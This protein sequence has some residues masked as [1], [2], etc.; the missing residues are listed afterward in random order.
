MIQL[1]GVSK[2]YG[3]ELGQ[4]T[5]LHSTSLDINAGELVAIVGA[6][7]SGKST[8][9]NIIGLLTAPTAG[10]VSIDGKICTGLSRTQLAR[11]RNSMFGFVF[12][13]YGLLSDLT[14]LENLE[15]PL[16][17]RGSGRRRNR[18]LEILAKFQLGDL[19]QRFPGELSGGQQQ[20]V[21]VARALVADAPIIL[22]DEP[23][24]ALDTQ[25]GQTVI[26][27]LTEA[28]KEGRTV[29]IVTHNPQI[30]NLCTRVISLADGMVEEG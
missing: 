21:A 22:A 27:Q 23:T 18:A 26:T 29:L 8:L 9:L 28:H 25:S 17:Y 2:K 15:L 1:G 12:Q 16:Y 6:S 3:K 19:A 7:G 4:V 14:V 20:R 5:A 10:T 30:A 11:M 24:G 13:H